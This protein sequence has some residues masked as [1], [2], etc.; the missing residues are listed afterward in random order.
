MRQLK[1]LHPIEAV[2]VVES[3][4][5]WILS[6]CDLPTDSPSGCLAPE[7]IEHLAR[8]ETVDAVVVNN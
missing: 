2:E 1:H 5:A 4:E 3:I 6:F 8:D 7:L